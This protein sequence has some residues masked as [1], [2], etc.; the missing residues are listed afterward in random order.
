MFVR[1][2][3]R[4]IYN[5][6]TGQFPS[7]VSLQMKNKIYDGPYHH[8]CTGTIISKTHVLSAAHCFSQNLAQPEQWIVVAGSI[9]PKKSN[10]YYVKKI[11]LHPEYMKKASI[12]DV[13]I[14]I[15]KG[16]FKLSKNLKVMGMANNFQIPK[17]TSCLISFQTISKLIVL[18]Y[19]S[20]RI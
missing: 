19:Q 18:F 10:T 9:F 2:I 14:V 17:G 1:T 3:Y 7:L 20:Y 6:S 5:S 4:F 12:D 8:R 16:E 13:A 11:K 15:I